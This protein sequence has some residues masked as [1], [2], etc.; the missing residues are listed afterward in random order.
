MAGKTCPVRQAET[1]KEPECAHGS[2]EWY[3][4]YPD[5]GGACAM[6]ITARRLQLVVDTLAR[7]LAGSGLAATEKSKERKGVTS[8]SPVWDDSTPR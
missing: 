5:G 7:I 1:G 8:Q 4:P 3:V 2:C 6:T